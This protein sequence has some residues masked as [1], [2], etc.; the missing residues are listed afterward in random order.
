MILCVG[1]RSTYTMSVPSS[2]EAEHDSRTCS[3]SPSITGSAKSQMGM[4]DR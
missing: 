3:T 2:T 4:D 1:T